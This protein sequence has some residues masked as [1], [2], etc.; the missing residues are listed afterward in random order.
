[1]AGAFVYLEY[2][3]RG[4]RGFF[5]QPVNLVRPAHLE[6]LREIFRFNREAP[7]LLDRP[8]ADGITLGEFLDERRFGEQFTWRCLM[9]MASAIWSA[10]LDAIRQFS[11]ATLIR[12]LDNHGL[13]TICISPT[14]KPPSSSVIPAS[15]S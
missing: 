14:A 12:F 1:M 4:A 10:S 11:A 5:A 6:L 7:R 9:P 8:D 3:S 15:S 13:L 2:S